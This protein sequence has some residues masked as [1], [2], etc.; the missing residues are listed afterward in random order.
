MF[1]LHTTGLT[2][3]QEPLNAAHAKQQVRVL[4]LMGPEIND[5]QLELYYLG[6]VV[7]L[8]EL[9]L[10]HTHTHTHTHTHARALA[11]TRS[12]TYLKDRERPSQ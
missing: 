3:Q 2:K 6:C 10:K 12:H 8:G 5:L 1:A 11:H 9:Q 4:E 7:V